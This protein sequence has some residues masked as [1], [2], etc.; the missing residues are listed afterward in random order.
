VR[1]ALTASASEERAVANGQL[2]SIAFQGGGALG[3]YAAGALDYI[4]EAQPDFRPACVS[5]VSIGAFTAA[6]VA[7]HPDNPVPA[8]KD[9]W[10]ELTISYPFLPQ[11][12]ERRLAMFGNPAFYR[13][14]SDYFT[15]P[16]WTYLYDLGPIR[17]TLPRYVDFERIASGDVGLVVTATNI[18]TGGIKEFTN[19]DPGD[20]ITIEHLIASGSLPPSY[21]PLAIDGATYWDGGLFDNT[22]LGALLSRISAR[23]AARMRVIVINLFPDTG[24]VPATMPEVFDRMIELQFAN[25]TKKDVQLARSINALLAVIEQL[26]SLQPGDRNPA[27]ADAKLE[28]LAKYKVFENIISISNTCVEDAS[29]SSDFSPA[30]IRRRMETGYADARSK[31]TAPPTGAAEVKSAVAATIRAPIDA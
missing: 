24:V 19:E 1:W 4:Y 12:I 31:L 13:P 6:I 23:D 22:P 27:L 7:S 9:F 30:S 8:L 3:A 20:P 28:E 14:R 11:K 15:L 25:K 5:G 21:P 10:D 16:S 18:V 2:T 29:G 17:Q 26:Q